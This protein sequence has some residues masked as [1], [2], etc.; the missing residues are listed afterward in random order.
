MNRI[1]ERFEELG[2]KGEK[3]FIAFITA[4]DPDLATTRSLV[5]ELERRGVD[6]IEL[7]VPFS[8]SL[9]DGPT[10]QAASERA[11]KNKV[12]LKDV[13]ALVKDLRRETEIPLALLTYYNPVYKCGLER[14]VKE[15]VEGGVDGV[16]VPDLPP[17]EGKELK[18]FAQKMGLDTIFLVAPTSTPER[19]KLV[20]RYSSGFIYY[21]SLT[22]VTGVREELAETIK[23]TINRIRR[24]TGKPIAVGFGISKPAQV[25]EIASFADGVIVGSA[26]VRKV[27]ENLGRK[28][29]VREVGKF[30]EDLLSG[31]RDSE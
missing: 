8:D 28:G 15:A 27:E 13:L 16:I 29:L 3:A 26:I 14:F 12:S 11:L 17:E 24:S 5:L 23:P 30:V 25:R 9:A 18:D 2:K 20:A 6:I 10:I 31:I 7:G 21:V 1:G 19:I 22:G 4:G